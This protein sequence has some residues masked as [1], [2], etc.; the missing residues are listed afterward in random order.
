MV[1]EKFG[2]IKRSDKGLTLKT[3]AFRIFHGGN[4]IFINSFDKFLFHS[5]TDVVPHFLEKLEI[6]FDERFSSVDHAL[7]FDGRNSIHRALIIIFKSVLSC[8]H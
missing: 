4:S 5:F 3:S 7:K 1:K 2:F 6:H 8:N